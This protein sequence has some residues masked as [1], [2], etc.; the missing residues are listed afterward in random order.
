MSGQR[1]HGQVGKQASSQ[2]SSLHKPPTHSHDLKDATWKSCTLHICSFGKIFKW[3][4]TW[5]KLHKS[6]W[7]KDESQLLKRPWES[8][9]CWLLSQPV[10]LSCSAPHSFFVNLRL[11]VCEMWDVPWRIICLQP[12]N[13]LLFCHYQTPL[14]ITG[15]TEDQLSHKYIDTHGNQTSFPA[16]II[17]G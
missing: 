13:V 17:M 11:S 6:A 8:W 10:H 16:N 7:Q 9:Q 2:Y 3:R 1:P 15:S 14:P 4:Q 5:L 12:Q